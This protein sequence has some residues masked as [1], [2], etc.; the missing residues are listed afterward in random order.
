MKGLFILLA[1]LCLPFPQVASAEAPTVRRHVP[2]DL[3]LE[4]IASDGDRHVT[5]DST[6]CGNTKISIVEIFKPGQTPEDAKQR[7]RG[8]V[9]TY[10]GFFYFETN[11]HGNISRSNITGATKLEIVASSDKKCWVTS[12]SIFPRD[13]IRIYEIDLREPLPKKP[14]ALPREPLRDF[15]NVCGIRFS[16]PG[17]RVSYSVSEDGETLILTPH[18]P[19]K[20][21]ED[22]PVKEFVYKDSSEETEGEVH[23][24]TSERQGSPDVPAS[25][26]EASA[27]NI[28]GGVL[29]LIAILGALFI[30]KRC[31]SCK[32]KK[33]K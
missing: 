19:G 11:T 2:F 22:F 6:T 25:E 16:H 31:C 27:Y 29:G 12:D 28:A 5:V 33:T 1:A 23:P 30:W 18:K 14:K 17:N 3:S 15:L 21:P 9:Y 32:A 13:V 8:P 4:E 10:T 20:K 7:I 24:A 26:P